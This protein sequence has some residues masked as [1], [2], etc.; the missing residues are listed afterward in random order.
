LSWVE[1]GGTLLVGEL[2]LF[3]IPAVVGLI[4]YG[5]VLM[6]FGIQIVIIITIS[7]IIVM[8]ITGIIAEHISRR[9][10]GSL[11]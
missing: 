8:S 9:K 3:F 11:K 10:E 2:L 6:H 4:N 7:T 1:Q 5:D